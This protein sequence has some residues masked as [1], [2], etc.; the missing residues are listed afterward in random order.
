MFAYIHAHLHVLVMRAVS[1]GEQV[2]QEIHSGQICG[3]DSF[4][5]GAPAYSSIVV[6]S[7][8]A[9]V[10]SCTKDQVCS[11]HMT[12]GTLRN[13]QASAVHPKLISARDT[14][15]VTSQGQQRRHSAMAVSHTLC[16][17]D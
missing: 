12:H 15:A 8:K 10:R 16:T 4:L 17:K 11:S 9:V 6:D 7:E 13:R 14:T 1:D 2:F 5:T 3:F